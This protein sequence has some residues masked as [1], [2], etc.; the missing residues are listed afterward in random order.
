[1]PPTRQTARRRP[2][3][4]PVELGPF[5]PRQRPCAS[6]RTLRS[7]SERAPT[8]HT[9]ARDGCSATCQRPAQSL[10]ARCKTGIHPCW[11]T[12]AIASARTPSRTDRL[13]RARPDPLRQAFAVERLERPRFAC[14]GRDEPSHVAALGASHPLGAHH[15]C[16]ECRIIELALTARL[17]GSIDASETPHARAWAHLALAAR[18]RL[19]RGARSHPATV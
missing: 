14:V 16:Q 11:A 8:A 15:L 9:A 13:R 1:M 7:Q 6:S 18:R 3:Q 2:R 4:R 10:R 17:G 19:A 5:S 12:V